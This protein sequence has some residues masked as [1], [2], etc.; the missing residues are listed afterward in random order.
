MTQPFDL[1][2]SPLDGVNLIEASAGTGKTYTLAGLYLRLILEKKLDVSQILVVTFTEAA[3]AELK[4]RVRKRLTGAADAF[5]SGVSDD[6]LIETLIRRST[7]STADRRRLA[8][9]I[10]D[11]DEAAI[12]TIHAFCRRML[13]DNAFESGGR[14]DTELST[15]PTALRRRAAEDFWR[16]H[17]YTA[18]EPF[19]QWVID[20]GYGPDGFM[21]LLNSGPRGFLSIIPEPEPA[22]A[23]EDFK[24]LESTYY[25]AF[26][27]A[28]EEWKSARDAVSAALLDTTVMNQN[29][30]KSASVSTWIAEL[31]HF[32]N[33]PRYTLSLPEKIEK[34]SSAFVKGGVKG[35]NPP[36]KH[37]FFDRVTELIDAKNALE[38]AYQQELIKLIISFF[39]QAEAS[40]EAQKAR[41]NI[42]TFDDLLSDLHRALSDRE[43]G[44]DAL[45]ERI[46]DRF[47]AA[48]ID[49]FQDTDPVQYAIFNRIFHHPETILFLIGDP[50]QAIYKFRGADV[51]AYMEAQGDADRRYTLGYNYRSEPGLVGAVNTVFSRPAAPFIYP[52]IPFGPVKAAGIDA[53]KTL[54]L[55]PDRPPLVI[56]EMVSPDG[57]KIGKTAARE[58]INAAVASEIARLVEMGRRE[59]AWIGDRPLEPGDIAVLVRA[60]Y[61]AEQIQAALR[62]LNV[63][64]VLYSTQ[65]LFETP[66]AAELELLLWAMARPG[67][68]TGLRTA[69]A[70]TLMD[71][72]GEAI[73]ALSRDETEWEALLL[74][75]RD[76]HDL[77]AS[78]GFMRAFREV[79]RREEIL[80]RLMARPDG[81]RRCTNLRHLAEVLNTADAVDRPGMDG[82]VKWLARQRSGETGRPDEHQLRLESDAEAVKLVTIHRSKGLEYPIVFCPYLWNLPKVD[83]NSPLFHDPEKGHQLTLDL[84]SEDKERHV[85]WAEQE[86][87]AENLRLF[88]VALTRA[89][90]RAT[91]V[92]GWF[93][94]AQA[95]A[96]AW[97]FHPPPDPVDDP[98]A[99]ISTH[100]NKLG[101]DAVG[102]DIREVARAAE[103]KL[104]VVPIPEAEADPLPPPAADARDLSARTFTTTVD[105]AYRVTSF[106]A[107]ATSHRPVFLGDLGEAPADYD[108]IDQPR[109][110]EKPEDT[111]SAEVTVLGDA[112]T[113]EA[114]ERTIFTF[115]RGADA[116]TLIHKILETIDFSGERAAIE[117]T[118]REVL[119]AY[120][121]DPGWVPVLTETIGNLLHTPLMPDDQPDLTLASVS[122]SERINEL[123]FYLPL[124]RITPSALAPLLDGEKAERSLTF[125]PVEGYLRGFIDLV[126]AYQNRFYLVDWK[127]NHLGDEVDAY[128]E[129]DLNRAMAEH[130]YD[131]QYNLYALA[132]DRYLSKRVPEYHYE[133]H[134]GG[135][136]YVFV[137]GI[138]PDRRPEYGIFR[139]RPEP[140]RIEWLRGF[141]EME[142]ERNHE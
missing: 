28:A 76:Y 90:N 124:R 105:T 6:S 84:G 129:S 80:P 94:K 78:R 2:A 93:N 39:E 64:A 19:V 96:P 137:R 92:W 44:G 13:V 114:P 134:F 1:E 14:F 16:S 91:F 31:N 125:S 89:R 71:Y 141:V 46:R 8:A 37:P 127:S 58:I 97:V 4:D 56:W 139:A 130:H 131:L 55:E 75:F 63:P 5:A 62:P 122:P 132:L 116:G 74:R 103:D 7:D 119:D 11:F 107:L 68:E 29:S 53:Q 45:A 104:S 115:P 111:P 10:R 23:P 77:W 38:A 70:T 118:V 21:A 128:Q 136:A 135:V 9:A 112:A 36:P 113:E 61:E 99:A 51:F 66:E 49:E 41:E 47:K 3:T 15:D 120:R 133:T 140:E 65:S 52:E 17:F 123:G 48:L 121:L 25:K 138:D 35:K 87:L 67:S 88:Y 18:P 126:F 12:F 73:E 22:P 86:D 20:Q 98:V 142:P 117:T 69:L 40:I 110:G 33:G 102:K 85:K 60:N 59:A 57:K 26:D 30:Y 24:E 101:G 81:E 109:Q 50:K 106:S 82:L 100:F 32:L 42:R 34:F 27:A 79:L 83:K 72:T 43:R 108:A 95:A 54:R